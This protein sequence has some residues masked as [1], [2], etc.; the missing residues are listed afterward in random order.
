MTVYKNKNNNTRETNVCYRDWRGEARRK[1]KRGFATKK[2]ALAWKAN[3]QSGYSGNLG[4]TFSQFFELYAKDRRPRL[5]LNTWISKE[6][7][8]KDKLLPYFGDKMIN[9][10]KP[11]D[12]LHWQNGLLAATNKNNE[13]YSQT[14]LRTINNQLVVIFSHACKFYGL[15]SNPATKAG[16]IGKK[17]ADTVKFCTLSEYETFSTAIRREPTTYYAFQVLYWTGIR[18]GELLALTAGD[19]DLPSRSIQITKSH[20]RLDGK[21]V[22]T[23][24]KTSKGVRIVAIP[25]SLCLELEK[26]IQ[27]SGFEFDDKLFSVSRYLLTKQLKNYASE[28]DLQPIKV[29]EFRHSHASLLIEF[30]CS[31]CLVADRLGHANITTTQRYIHLLPNKSS[32]IAEHLDKEMQVEAQLAVSNI[33]VN[34]YKTRVS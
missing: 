25:S 12:I 32:E 5:R 9:E 21:D 16:I 20:Q 29:H 27:I 13:P 31:L 8:F 18:V 23:E 4:V 22:I 6:Y 33:S 11:R 24:P 15:E 10:I 7:I 17:H 26:Y 34:A 28:T 19:I 2:E 30:G 14:Y 3:F 1:H